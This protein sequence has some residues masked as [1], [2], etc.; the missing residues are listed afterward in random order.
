MLSLKT[1]LR[2]GLGFINAG[3]VFKRRAL[4]KSRKN[5]TFFIFEGQE[6]TYGDVY[7]NALQY[8]HFF[9]DVR[10]ERQNRGQMG[11]GE[12]LAVGLYQENTPEYVFALFGAALSDTTIFGINT[13][14]RGET[15]V[16]V[17]N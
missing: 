6:F 2:K 4:A 16:N 3:S 7:E 8:S 5:K 12:K 14:F 17:I 11:P 15:L 1:F 13:G 9:H 10:K